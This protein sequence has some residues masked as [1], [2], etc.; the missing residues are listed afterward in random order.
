MIKGEDSTKEMALV[1][2]EVAVGVVIVVPVVTWLR[3]CTSTL[4]SVACKGGVGAEGCDK[5]AERVDD[6]HM[7]RPKRTG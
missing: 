2:E 1:L 5:S 7:P 3:T 6:S 4:E